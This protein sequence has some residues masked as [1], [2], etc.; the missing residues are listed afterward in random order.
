VMMHQGT[1]GSKL[2]VEKKS[3]INSKNTAVQIKGRGADVLVDDAVLNP[4]NGILIQ[5]M[6]NDDP[7]MKAMAMGGPGGPPPGGPGEAPGAGPG[8]P[9][10]PPPGGPGGPPGGP[11]GAPPGDMPGAGSMG[12]SPDVHAT[13]SNTELKGDV[14]HAL[15]SQS[16]MTVSLQAAKLSG[17][18]STGIALPA[19]GEAPSRETFRTVGEVT[20][21]LG[22][23]TTEHG[24]K[25]YLDWTSRWTVSR[26]SYLDG[27]VIADGAEVAAPTD[28]RLSMTVDGVPTPIRPGAYDGAIVLEVSSGN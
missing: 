12:F 10:G 18:I 14:I 15:T 3:V 25:V 9:G 8:G 13:F 17:A 2:T 6:E 1:G 11:G 5:T 20:N 28:A 4:A 19:S 22:P 26:T 7:I 21:T 16:D 23:S 24:L 27:L